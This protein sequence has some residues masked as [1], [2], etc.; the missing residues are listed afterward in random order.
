[1][2]TR[3]SRSSFNAETPAA[4]GERSA[5]H[6]ATVRLRSTR[7]IA[8][9]ATACAPHPSCRWRKTASE[10]RST[11]VPPRADGSPEASCSCRSA[12]LVSASALSWPRS[13][14]PCKASAVRPARTIRATGHP[15]GTDLDDAFESRGGLARRNLDPPLHGAILNGSSK[16]RGAASR[17]VRPQCRPG[18]A[19]EEAV[20]AQDAA[21][22]IAVACNVRQ[23]DR[24]SVEVGEVADCPGD[25]GRVMEPGCLRGGLPINPEVSATKQRWPPLHQSVLWMR[26]ARVIFTQRRPGA[27]A[28]GG[29]ASQKG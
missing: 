22:Q 13:S 10:S 20:V 5:P 2:S 4:P 27:C 11:R 19:A 21:G 15:H 26:D 9:Q 24:Q 7:G 28:L 8:W 12:A 18:R 16:R 14:R 29:I 3:Q 25:L 17:K 6:R 1:M 23:R